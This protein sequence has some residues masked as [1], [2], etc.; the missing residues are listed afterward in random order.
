MYKRHIAHGGGITRSFKWSVNLLLN[1]F[2]FYGASFFPGEPLHVLLLPY[3]NVTN[4]I[5][6]AII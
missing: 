1:Y 4:V 2:I 5:T 6:Q 3:F